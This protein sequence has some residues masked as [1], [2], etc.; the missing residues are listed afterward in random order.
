MCISGLSHRFRA[1]RFCPQK[2]DER[3]QSY[4]P[5]RRKPKTVYH[6]VRESR[7]DAGQEKTA[8]GA[9]GLFAFHRIAGQFDPYQLERT[10][11]QSGIPQYL[12]SSRA[13]KNHHDG[14]IVGVFAGRTFLARGAENP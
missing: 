1:Q 6:T 12:A 3:S 8:A 9:H 5:G 4:Y 13:R 11:F 7:R 2:A 14:G 10:G